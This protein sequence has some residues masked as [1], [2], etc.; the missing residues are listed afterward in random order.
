M[1][2]NAVVTVEAGTV[3]PMDLIARAQQANA[4]IESM[5]QLFELQLRYEQNEAKKAYFQAVALFK[6]EAVDI[7][8]N[9]KV[10]Y[11]TSKGVTEYNHAELGQVVNTVTPLLSKHGLSHHWEYFQE[12]SKIKVTCFLTHEMG[13]EKSTS[14]EAGADDSG[15]KNSIQAIGSTTSYLERYTFLAMTGLASREQDDDGKGAGKK[16]EVEIITEQQTMDLLCLI[17]EVGADE[18]QFCTYFKVEKVCFLPAAKYPNA[19]KML[20]AKRNK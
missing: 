10:K 17:K 2:K 1:E 5:A 20:E 6:A 15:G 19:V 13:Y 12:G 18:D 8:K 9:K 4:S 11:S 3:T 7:V 16:V 14:L